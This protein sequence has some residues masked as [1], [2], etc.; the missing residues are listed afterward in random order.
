[1]FGQKRVPSRKGGVEVVVTNLAIRMAQKNK[2]ILYDHRE[3][4]KGLKTRI[5]KNILIKTVPTIHLKGLAAVSSAF[6]AS[7]F[8]AFSNCDVV[9]IHAEGPAL[10][11][12]I[13][14]LFHKRVVVTVHGLNWQSAKWRNN[15][16]GKIIKLG[17]RIA[18]RYA[19]EIIVLNKTTQNYFKKAYSRETHFIPNGVSNPVRRKATEILKMW[20]I[21]ENSYFLFLGRIIPGKGIEK[22]IE[23][24]K[25]LDTKKKLVIAGGSSDSED[26]FLK[27]KELAK[28][29]SNI[30]FTGPVEG[31]VLDELYSNAFLYV[32]PSDSEGMPLTLLEAMS[33]GN[34][35]LVSDIPECLDVIDEHGLSFTTNNV[36]DLYKKLEYAL[37]HKN[38]VKELKS[39]SASFILRKYNWDKVVDQTIALYEELISMKKD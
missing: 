4:D 29:N 10:F 19:D 24:Y 2:V 21:K 39:K 37:M 3:G 32:L 25:K 23:A 8:T 27:V 22:L 20:G 9:H 33:Y 17:E 5:Y 16:G 11:C 15:F 30:I 31:R 34:C 18:V 38:V 12:W 36:N 14:K 13:P 6:F 26:F 7:I 1:M 35:V 28:D